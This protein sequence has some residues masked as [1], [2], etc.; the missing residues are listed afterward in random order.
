MAGAALGLAVSHVVGD[1]EVPREVGQEKAGEGGVALE[2]VVVLIVVHTIT[3]THTHSH[4]Y[5][6]ARAARTLLVH[7]RD[8]TRRSPYSTRL[9]L[10]RVSTYLG[11]S[12]HQYLLLSRAP[13]V[14]STLRI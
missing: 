12:M 1:F 4:S 8:P 13:C 10:R 14:V 2:R 3:L 11:Y 7:T 6:R 5:T 9:H